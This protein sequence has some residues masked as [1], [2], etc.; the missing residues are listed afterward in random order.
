EGAQGMAAGMS[1]DAD[2]SRLTDGLGQRWAT[3]E[4]SFKYFASCR[5]THPAADA[6]QSVLIREQIAWQDIEHVEAFVHQAA[7]DVLG[8]VTNPQSVHQAKF[9][10]GTVLAL[11]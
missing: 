3:A 9:S 1:Q 2:A 8:P 10:M 7:I 6:L 11:V 4:T 5:H